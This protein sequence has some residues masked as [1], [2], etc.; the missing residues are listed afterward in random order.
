MAL[1]LVGC[2]S[3]EVIVAPPEPE[4]VLTGAN[5]YGLEVIPTFGLELD[6]AAVSALDAEPKV[7]TPGTFVYNGF[8]IENVG[9]RL[10]GNDT[11]TPLSEK[12]SFKVKFN[13][14]VKGRRFLGREGLTL[15]NMHT[16]PS[17]LRE[18]LAYEVF[19]SM[20]VPGPRTGYV[21][22][23][24]NQEPYGLYLNL[25]PYNDDFLE[26]R[27][28]DPSGNLYEGDHGDD[29]Q[30]DVS[31]W[32]Q[33][34]G[35]DTSRDDLR[36]LQAL[37]AG[38]VESYFYGDEA[39]IEREE[40]FGFIAAEAFV[41]HFDGYQAPHNF[42]IYN[43]PTEAQW[44]FLPWNLDQG[45]YRATSPF[46]G[47]GYLTRA[48]IDQSERCITDYAARALDEVRKLRA[49]DLPGR[50]TMA[51][52]RIDWA[53]RGDQ[54]KRHSQESMEASIAQLESWVESRLGNFEAAADCLVDGHQV[55]DDGDGWGTCT[56]DCNDAD[57][58]VHFGAEEVCDQ[59]DNNCSGFVDDVPACPCPS[60]VIE[61]VEFFFCSHVIKWFQA[62]QFCEAQ[63]HQLAKLESPEQNAAVWSVAHGIRSGPWAIGLTDSA[64]EGDFRYLDG[65]EPSFT[66][67]A[68]GEPA[69]RLPIFDCVY[70][71]GA[72]A[73]V[74]YEGNCN[75][76]GAFICSD[77]P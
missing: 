68:N 25:E 70:F 8:R 43:E 66:S 54:K 6:E 21:L 75:E 40:F 28:Q 24:V 31:T 39:P 77:A 32:D 65:S 52:E 23:E 7:Y 61:G 4:P 37:M 42:F 72:D 22:V 46:F 73:P 9:I 53:A 13:K 14:Y 41:G 58:S 38:D 64:V 44:Y 26:E 48:C 19:R 30:R 62:R 50:L 27:F 57:P 56:H 11:L 69:Q 2:G 29:V 59:V 76:S 3:D 47:A 34:E 51:K 60:E 63:G 20:G 33:D 17:M 10:K 12:P 74:W 67:W 35:E 71:L 18:W 1:A 36:Q 5:L 15:N 49:E 45:F 16:D 55:D